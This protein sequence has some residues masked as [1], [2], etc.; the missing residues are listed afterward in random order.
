MSATQ[1]ARSGVPLDKQSIVT[2]VPGFPWWGVVLLGAGVTAVGFL[3]DA[4]RGSELTAAFSTF[5]FLGCV[6][7]AVAASN[8]AL[9]TAMVQPPL[10]LFVGVPIAQTLIGDGMGAGIR[11]I[12]I[13]VAYPLVNRFPVMLAATIVAVAICGARIFLLQKRRNGPARPSTRRRTPRSERDGAPSRRGTTRSGSAREE[14]STHQNSTPRSAG[15]PPRRDSS[16][17]PVG[18]GRRASAPAND[19]RPTRPRRSAT[20]PPRGQATS[21]RPFAD[22]THREPPPR[23]EPS[24]RPRASAEVPAHP[25]PQVRYRDRY[26]PPFESER[27][28]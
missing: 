23:R 26:E 16:K 14:K 19:G 10:I 1:R 20:P 13:N 4:A 8:R 7:A 6:G 18:Q 15:R 2:T 28:Y 12:A 5:Y 27:R 17:D 21:G 22:R 24:P 9:F 11:D 25:I 3:V